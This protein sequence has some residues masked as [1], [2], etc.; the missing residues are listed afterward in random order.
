MDRTT[1]I[2]TWRAV[3]GS[4]MIMALPPTGR[5]LE[6]FAAR[7]EAAEREAC[8]QIAERYEPDEK[9]LDVAYASRDIRAR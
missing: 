1:A 3:C 2:A 9:P 5:M 4:D 8:A 6:E 7:I